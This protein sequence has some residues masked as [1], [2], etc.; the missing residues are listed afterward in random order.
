MGI[1]PNQ[2]E[3]PAAVKVHPRLQDG[4]AVLGQP[5]GRQMR[6]AD[7]VARVMLDVLADNLSTLLTEEVGDN[8]FFL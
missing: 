6:C 5:D 1:L 7:Q 2:Q 3:A 8:G 4:A